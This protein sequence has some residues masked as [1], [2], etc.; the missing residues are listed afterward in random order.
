MKINESIFTS[1]CIHVWHTVNV[2]SKKWQ[3]LLVWWTGSSLAPIPQHL[4]LG[5]SPAGSLHESAAWNVPPLVSCFDSDF[6]LLLGSVLHHWCTRSLRSWTC[7][8]LDGQF[9]LLRQ[10]E[11]KCYDILHYWKQETKMYHPCHSASAVALDLFSFSL[12][13]PSPLQQSQRACRR[14][15][16]KGFNYFLSTGMGRLI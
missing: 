14:P 5:W 15:A 9:P 13:P 10:L 3:R 8:V 11:F 6:P 4:P 2:H 7:P 12:M 1:H 16:W